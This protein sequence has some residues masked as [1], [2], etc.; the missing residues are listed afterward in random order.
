MIIIIMTTRL[1]WGYPPAKEEAVTDGRIDQPTNQP[2]IMSKLS[3]RCQGGTWWSSPRT[4]VRK[5]QETE[6]GEE[7][8]ECQ[9]VCRVSINQHERL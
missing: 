1:C 7:E 3:P 8:K 9:P 6:G 5:Q 4:H 2:T